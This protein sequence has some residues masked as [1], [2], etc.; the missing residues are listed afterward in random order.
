MYFYTKAKEADPDT[1]INDFRYPG[2]NPQTKEAGII[3][4]ADGIEASVR[5]MDE[6][7]GDAIRSQIEKMCKMRMEDG[8]LDDCDLS[9]KDIN[10]V[11]HSFA[12]TLTAMYHTRIKY[13]SDKK[14]E[15]KN[16][17]GNS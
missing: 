2:P 9:L 15:E 17:S 8:E 7:N 13:E 1:D 4:L 10:A 11:K 5:A 12:Q 6:K 3:L 14:V 16:E